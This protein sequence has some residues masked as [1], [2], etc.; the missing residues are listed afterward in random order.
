MNAP[1]CIGVDR[2]GMVVVYRLPRGR[3]VSFF[4]RAETA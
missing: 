4:V 1:H 3:W 2:T